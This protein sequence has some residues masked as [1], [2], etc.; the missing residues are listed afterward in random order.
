MKAKD[1][2]KQDDLCE[3]IA[4]DAYIMSEKQKAAQL[5]E[6][7]QDPNVVINISAALHF[8]ELSQGGVSKLNR[9]LRASLSG[10]SDDIIRMVLDKKMLGRGVRY[11]FEKHMGKKFVKCGDNNEAIIRSLSQ[12]WEE[13]MADCRYNSKLH[14]LFPKAPESSEE[15]KVQENTYFA[16]QVA[17]ESPLKRSKESEKQDDDKVMYDPYKVRIDLECLT[18]QAEIESHFKD[19]LKEIEPEMKYEPVMLYFSVFFL[20][21]F[22]Y[23]LRI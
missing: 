2:E 5:K 13:I 3:D 18:E 8:A 9:A 12:I 22:C 14:K 20:L 6:R 15:S 4:N 7:L 21:F 10:Y 17:S 11:Y 1:L 23:Y 16:T 19:K